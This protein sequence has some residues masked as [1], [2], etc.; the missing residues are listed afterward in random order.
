[1]SDNLTQQLIT[2]LLEPKGMDWITMAPLLL[3]TLF[4]MFVLIPYLSIWWRGTE[5]WFII[6]HL[7]KK[8]KHRI[9]IMAHN[10]GGGFLGLFNPSYISIDDSIKI[11]RA[12]RNTPADQPIDLLL[13]TPGGMVLAAEQITGALK[14]H[15]GGFEV[16]IP[17]FAMSGGTLI[18]LAA[19]KIHMNK[20]AVLGPL[21]PQLG[22]GMFD[23]FPAVSILKAVAQINQNRED[24]TLIMADVARKAVRQIDNMVYGIVRPRL[25]P[26]KAETLTQLLTDGRYTHDY[27]INFH[28]ALGLG[29]W[30]D[31]VIP[32]E[33]YKLA[34]TFPVASS[35][36]YRKRKEEKS[37]IQIHL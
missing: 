32:K 12:I 14:D 3:S 26:E 1:M 33:I 36:Q 19:S 18:A 27:G 6:R 9:I 28:R 17:Y 5:R 11:M 4:L 7:E 30:V 16:Y 20:H 8:T 15:P 21:D 35:V 10:S 31:D 2:K 29:L 24:K 34:E 23:S 25:S 37:E 22:M 13:H